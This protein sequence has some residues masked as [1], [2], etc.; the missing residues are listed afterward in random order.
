MIASYLEVT[1]SNPRVEFPHLFVIDGGGMIRSDFG[2]SDSNSLTVDGVSAAIEKA[3]K[4]A[5]LSPGR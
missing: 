3:T 1:P 5:Q 2:E 4:P